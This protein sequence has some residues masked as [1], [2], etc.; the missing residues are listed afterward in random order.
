M[1]RRPRHQEQEGRR[2]C[3]KQQGGGRKAAELSGSSGRGRA[4]PSEGENHARRSE[5]GLLEAQKERRLERGPIKQQCS[6]MPRPNK[7]LK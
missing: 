4:A 1:T 2:R 3:G 5:R 7:G 6:T